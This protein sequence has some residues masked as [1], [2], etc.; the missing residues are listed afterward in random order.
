MK[1]SF[2]S[3]LLALPLLAA[4]APKPEAA[5]LSSRD[6]TVTQQE[7]NGFMYMRQLAS[8]AYCNSKDSLVGQKVTCSNNACPDIGA[9]NVVNFAHLDTDIGIKADG[10]V[11]I[12]HTR[13]GIVMSF[14]GSKSW[15]SFMTDLDFTGSDSSEI[16]SGCTVHYGIKLTYDIIEGALINALNS[17]RA[18]WPSYQVVATGHSIGA[19]VATVA[20]ARLRNRLNVDIQLYTFGSP[21]VGNDAFATFVTNQNR[22]RNY[23][24]THYDDVV[25]ALPPS[26]AGFA[27]VSPEYWLRR[28]DASDFNYPLSEVVVCEGIN[29]KGCR[30]SMGTTLSGKAHGEYFGAISACY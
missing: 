1:V 25:A 26:W 22:G 14:M 5:E 10:A 18:Q 13:G 8:A 24:I 16:C 23:R 2:V 21:R 9:A 7:L 11:F 12:D 19:G 30:N 28:K 17:A 29:P 3:S 4:A 20:A 27:H 6:V 15:Q